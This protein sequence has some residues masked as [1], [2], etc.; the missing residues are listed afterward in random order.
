MANRGDVFRW[1]AFDLL[2]WETADTLLWYR[3]N[4]Y[5]L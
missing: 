5:E 3:V 4:K 2:K 1:D